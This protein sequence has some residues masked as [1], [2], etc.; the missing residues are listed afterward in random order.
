M[1]SNLAFLRLRHLF[2]CCRRIADHPHKDNWMTVAKVRA[3]ER[4]MWSLESTSCRCMTLGSLV[5]LKLSRLSEIQAKSG[6]VPGQS[7]AKLKRGKSS[8]AVLANS[9]D[10]SWLDRGI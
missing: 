10:T 8:G 4:I 9:A 7:S 5:L 2:T 3:N 1:I 6:Q